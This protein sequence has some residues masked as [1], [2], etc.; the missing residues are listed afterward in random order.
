MPATIKFD[1]KVLTLLLGNTPEA[2]EFISA[3]KRSLMFDSIG[4]ALL[5]D[6]P[7]TSSAQYATLTE[8]IK[9]CDEL[10]KILKP[11]VQPKSQHIRYR[12]IETASLILRYRDS[13][14][15][16]KRIT[17][18]CQHNVN[19]TT[20]LTALENAFEGV[21]TVDSAIKKD[22][23]DKLTDK[24]SH[25]PNLIDIGKLFDSLQQ[26]T[27]I[28]SYAAKDIKPGRG[29][30]SNLSP[31]YI[32]KEKLSTEFVFWY[33]HYFNKLPP[34]TKDGPAHKAFTYCLDIAGFSEEIDSFT[35]LKKAIE[36]HRWDTTF[37]SN[38]ERLLKSY[39]VPPANMHTR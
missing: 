3:L 2:K 39:G 33:L 37:R 6:Y 9:K 35:C 36:K 14:N 16:N 28:V 30:S 19:K 11:I 4:Q 1:S 34:K 25:D 21:K 38:Y 27:E 12:D 23:P 18:N 8:I 22:E 10:L 20:N 13:M 17:Q 26:F 31:E 29:N 15:R 7:K 5:D 24:N 32:R